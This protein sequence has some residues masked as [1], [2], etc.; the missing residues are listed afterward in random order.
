MPLQDI[1]GMTELKCTVENPQ[2][3]WP[4]GLGTQPLYK[5]TVELKESEHE[6]SLDQWERKIGLRTM[7]VS[8][9]ADEWGNGFAVTVNGI[10]IFSMG[11]DYIPEA[12]APTPMTSTL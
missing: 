1:V 7:T 11:A 4:N 6:T 2:L 3:W 10:S 9:K 12:A 5:A 8:T